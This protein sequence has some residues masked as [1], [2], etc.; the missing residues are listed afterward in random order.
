MRSES[1]PDSVPPKSLGSSAK[2]S[3][4]PLLKQA[5]NLFTVLKVN[6]INASKC[7]YNHCHLFAFFSILLMLY[8]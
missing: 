3:M 2:S 5:L 4:F 7:S 8:A 6:K 1:D